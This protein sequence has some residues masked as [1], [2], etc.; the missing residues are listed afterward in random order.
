MPR[1]PLNVC[2][3]S[4]GAP[5]DRSYEIFSTKQSGDFDVSVV[6]L[7]TCLTDILGFLEKFGG[8]FKQEIDDKGEKDKK[9]E[10]GDG[11]VCD[12][13]N[14]RDMI[15]WLLSTVEVTAADMEEVIVNGDSPSP[16]RTIDG[17]EQSYPPTTTEE[18]LA[19][20]NELKER[21]TLLMALPN[22]L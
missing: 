21:G 12:L 4:F 5:R 15:E 9:D 20:K 1:L 7:Q 2:S 18:K 17:V 6:R 8:R 10:E 16:L 11:E 22:E 13:N 19:R 3:P 14:E